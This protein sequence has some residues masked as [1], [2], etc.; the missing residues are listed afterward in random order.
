[1][2]YKNQFGKK[3]A[4]TEQSVPIPYGIPEG[5]GSVNNHGEEQIIENQSVGK[6]VYLRG[7]IQFVRSGCRKETTGRRIIDRK[8]EELLISHKVGDLAMQIGR[9]KRIN[10]VLDT[11]ITIKAG[12][13]DVLA[14]YNTTNNYL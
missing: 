7:F 5:L 2:G 11:P 10:A 4:V 14:V 12:L 9:I 3:N 1:M 6:D 13:T 8:N